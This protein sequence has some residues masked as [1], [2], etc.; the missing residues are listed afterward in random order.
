MI[1]TSPA[2]VHG[3]TTLSIFVGS[4]EAA[5]TI[6]V[7]AVVGVVLTRSG[8]LSEEF[9]LRLLCFAAHRI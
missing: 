1:V 8:I 3:V 4:L 9:V 6:S 2:D 7:Q 5:A